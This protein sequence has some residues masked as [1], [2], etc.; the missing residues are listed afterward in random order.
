MNMPTKPTSQ[1]PTR[2]LCAPLSVPFEPEELDWGYISDPSTL[3]RVLG[4]NASW[5]AHEPRTTLKVFRVVF[6]RLTG[7][8]RE[9][10]EEFRDRLNCALAELGYQ[11]GEGDGWYVT[12]SQLDGH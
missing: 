2:S 9:L 11:P 8:N 12:W 4:D 5:L 3:R 1:A 6:H 10:R 7:L